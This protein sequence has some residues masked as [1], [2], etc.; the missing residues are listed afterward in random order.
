MFVIIEMKSRLFVGVR[1]RLVTC[2][3]ADG[4]SGEQVPEGGGAFGAGVEV[5]VNRDQFGWRERSF[6]V[7]FELRTCAMLSHKQGGVDVE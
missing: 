2:S 4:L 3:R 7:A 5:I 1:G 6:A